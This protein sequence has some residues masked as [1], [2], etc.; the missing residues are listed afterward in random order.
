MKPSKW[1]LISV[2]FSTTNVLLVSDTV[3]SV[4]FDILDR[5]PVTSGKG[6]TLTVLFVS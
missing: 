1:H 4:S 2:T 6:A 5:P 3:T